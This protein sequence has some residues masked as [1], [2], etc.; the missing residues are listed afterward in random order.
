M[1]YTTTQIVTGL[2]EQA[3]VPVDSNQVGQAVDDSYPIIQEYDFWLKGTVDKEVTGQVIDVDAR[4]EGVVQPNARVRN[5]SARN[6]NK[7]K[8][9]Y[10]STVKA[11]ADTDTVDLNDD[12]EFAEGDVYR[13]EDTLKYELA[14]R[15]KA[16]AL[17]TTQLEGGTSFSTGQDE[18]LGPISVSDEA[19]EWGHDRPANVFEK[20]FLK[21]VGVPHAAV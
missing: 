16:A 6:R 11:V 5:I 4:F 20:E 10:Q 12:I 19:A 2:L 13:I 21:I 15:Y 1:S 17:Y 18:S 3:G 7:D 9:E 8:S 14:Q